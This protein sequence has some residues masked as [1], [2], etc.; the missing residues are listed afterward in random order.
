MKA[1]LATLGFAVLAVN[2]PA[3]FADES[4]IEQIN[5]ACLQGLISRANPYDLINWKVGDTANYNLTMSFL[6]GK[7]VESV[8]S[9]EGKAIWVR[10]AMDLMI[11]KEVIDILINKADGKILKMLR[12]G[13]EMQVPNDKITIISQ[14]YTEVTVPAGTFKCIH[15]VAKSEQ[16]PKIEIWANPQA[17]VMEGNLKQIATTQMGEILL[18]L[19]SFAHGS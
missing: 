5:N 3:S 19:T 7:M 12:N 18:E 17:T 16:M 4:A 8:T 10:Q 1:F 15:V 13:Q 11:Q 2:A 14:E 6:K 9:D